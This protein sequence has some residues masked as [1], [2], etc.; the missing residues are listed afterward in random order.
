MSKRT[1][2]ILGGIAV[3][4]VGSIAASSLANRG[5]KAVE[6]KIEP[7]EKRDLVASVT[8]SGQVQPH[9]KVDVASDISGRSFG[10][11][12]RK[13]RWC[14]QGPVPAPDRSASS[15]RPR[16]SSAEAGL[17]SRALR[18]R[19]HERTCCSRS[20]T[21]IGRPRSRRTNP[22]LVSD[23]ASSSLRTQVEVNEALQEAATQRRRSR[24]ASVRDCHAASRQDDD[25]RADGGRVTRLIVEQGETAIPGTF[26]KDAATLLTISDMSVLETKVKVDETDV[27]RIRVGDSAVDPDRRLPRHDVR[28]SRDRDL[29]QL[30]ARA[31]G[32]ARPIRRSTTR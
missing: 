3:L 1:K 16:C 30:R 15:T 10:S 19:R 13:A 14:T 9:T 8:A 6:V 24:A 5:D 12:S 17:S 22:Q 4:V 26:N 25:L 23:G 31:A 11:R 29:E 28:R 7:V 27:A 2:W 21:T 32:A 20:A 18:R